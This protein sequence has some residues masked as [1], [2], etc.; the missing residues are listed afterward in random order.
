MTEVRGR[1]AV[2]TGASRGIGLA[3]ATALVGEGATVVMLARGASDLEH[4]AR[5]LGTLAVPLPCD[6]AD[7]L[8]IDRATA[9]IRR[10]HGTPQIIVNNAGLFHLLPIDRT[11]TEQFVAT[12]NTNLVGPFEIVRAF[13]PEMRSRETGH[14][15][16]IGSIADRATFPDNGAYAASKHG[17]RA[18]HE[19]LRAETRGSGVRATLISPA[20]VDTPLWDDVDPDNR[21]GFTPRR[22]MLA[23]AAVAAAVLYALTQRLDVNVDE[24]RLSRS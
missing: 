15:V 12:I 6:I 21:A 24:L 14:I 17:L 10:D 13:L 5:M 2:V 19:V 20:P 4:A 22:A 9:V 8:A 16:T 1:L 3:V 7:P 11:T 23:P 18:F